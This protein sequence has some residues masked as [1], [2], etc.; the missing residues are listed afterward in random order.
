[1][2][3]PAVDRSPCIFCNIVNKL[4]DTEL[5]FEDDEVCVF[6]DIKPAA[7]FHVLTIPK[8]HINDVKSLTSA[9]KE[10][11]KCGRNRLVYF[12]LSLLGEIFIVYLSRLTSVTSLL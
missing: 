9:D 12:L 2:A 10:L 1:M 5:L 6:R 8:R 3:S 7:G 11:G 4:G